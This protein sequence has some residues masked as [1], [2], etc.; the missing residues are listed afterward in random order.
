[1]NQTNES[2]VH[3]K[4]CAWISIATFFVI[5]KTWSQPRCPVRGEWFSKQKQLLSNRDKR[6]VDARDDLDGSTEKCWVRK[7][8]PKEDT[9]WGSICVTFF[10]D[11]ILEKHDSLVGASVGDRGKEVF[12]LC[13][14]Y[15]LYFLMFCSLGA[16]LILGRLPV[17]GIA[18]S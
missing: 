2:Y 6:T 18:N 14:L 17:P 7:A 1:M 8:S 13:L 9:L 10:K 4:T 12:Q 11:K 16:L 5:S 3:T 15:F